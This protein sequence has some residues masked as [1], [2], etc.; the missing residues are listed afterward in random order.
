VSDDFYS[1]AIPEPT[2]VLGLRLRPFSL[3]H[4]I[5]LGRVRS[6]FVTEGEPLSLHDLA[7]SVL[8]CS[9]SYTDGLSLFNNRNLDRFFKRWHSRLAGESWLT[10]LGFRKLR[11]IDYAQKAVEFGEYIKRA[12]KIPNYS[13]R[14]DDFKQIECP[15]V[16]IVKVTLMRD[17]GFRE[18]E[19]MDRP[20]GL[21]LWDYVTIRALAGHISL[22]DS[23]QLKEAQAAADA[24]AERIKEGQW[25]T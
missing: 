10:R 18:A 22:V 2:T 25:P 12:S 11:E 8:I 1:A 3:G 21:C 4:V 15:S 13:Y 5:L 6:S 9:L 7:L 16:Q 24:L 20:W 23:D 19:L 14:A 17:M